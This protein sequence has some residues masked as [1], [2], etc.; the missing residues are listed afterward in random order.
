M[1]TIAKSNPIKLMIVEDVKEVRDGLRYLLNLDS[2]K[3]GAKIRNARLMRIPAIAVVG[4]REVD[5]RG[6]SLRTRASGD[7]GFKPLDEFLEWMVNESAE[8]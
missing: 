1:K 7:I 8:P 3:L 2:E 6:V 4:D 5:Q